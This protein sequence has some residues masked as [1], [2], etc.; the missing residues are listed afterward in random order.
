MA[1]EMNE[2]SIDIQQVYF[3]NELIYNLSSS[4]R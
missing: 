3:K 4:G 1:N 2:L